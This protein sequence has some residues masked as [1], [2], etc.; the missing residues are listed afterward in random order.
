MLDTNYISLQKASESVPFDSNYLGLLIRNGRLFG[1]KKHGK[2]YTTK[3]SLDEYM[4]CSTKV[5]ARKESSKITHPISYIAAGTVLF[6]GLFFFTIIGYAFVEESAERQV[7]EQPL[8]EAYGDPETAVSE[9]NGPV[10]SLAI[11]NK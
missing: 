11:R 9:G 4:K 5:S 8:L 6:T 3:E 10:S 1:V 2:W 7:F